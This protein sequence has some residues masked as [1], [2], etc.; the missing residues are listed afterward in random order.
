MFDFIIATAPEPDTIPPDAALA[1]T[2]CVSS[3]FDLISSFPPAVIFELFET[4]AFV[5]VFTFETAADT[6][7]AAAPSDAP[8]TST[9]TLFLFFAEIVTS[10]AVIFVFESTN[11]E[12]V[13]ALSV[14]LYVAI[15][16]D[17]FLNKSLS[18]C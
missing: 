13:F 5:V 14:E 16:F 3:E 7:T 8:F 2:F 17:D 15:A 11:A 9:S 18:P 6:P 12:V 10:F 4:K 1:V